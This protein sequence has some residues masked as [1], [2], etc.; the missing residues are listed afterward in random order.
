[1]LAPRKKLWSTP[2]SA[3]DMALEFAQPLGVDDVVY[4]IGCGD[5]RVLIEMASRSIPFTNEAYD[6]AQRCGDDQT[7]N[8]NNKEVTS[9]MQQSTSS[10]SIA[11]ARTT[12]TSQQHYCTKFIGIDISPERVTEARNNIQK[13]RTSNHIPPHVSI[14][15]ICGNA[16]DTD[17]V[18]IDY[19]YA[20]VIF[21][22]LV[23]RG[24][25]L[26]KPLVW[27]K[28]EEEEGEEGGVD[29][30]KGRVDDDDDTVGDSAAKIEEE[31]GR[32]APQLL[33]TTTQQQ[34][35]VHKNKSYKRRRTIIT[36]MSPFE[37]ETYVR[38]ELCRVEHQDGA[39]WP[40]YLY[41]TSCE[42][43]R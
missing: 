21:L 22:Y 28:D 41:H 18:D 31:G 34:Q 23:P 14:E 15:I 2:S 42:A 5:G 19:T 25:R 6:S 12:T 36:Y 40:V 16:L 17:N 7:K 33:A 32:T 35:L 11:A 38:K 29:E 20:T 39:A 37:D 43:K 13:A 30:D 4:D 27:P 9:S 8:N 1:M 26:I 3:I 10:S 24:L